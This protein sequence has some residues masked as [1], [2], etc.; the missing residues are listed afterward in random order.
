MVGRGQVSRTTTKTTNAVKRRRRIIMATE[1]TKH[2]SVKTITTY[3]YITEDGRVFKNETDAAKWG[4]II[5]VLKKI[6]MFYSNR[7]LIIHNADWNDVHSVILEN[8][9][10]VMALRTLHNAEYTYGI[11]HPGHW[12]WDHFDDCFYCLEDRIEEYTA[13]IKDMDDKANAASEV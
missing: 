11:D 6:K 4:A 7:E 9:D 5:H 2:Y 1:N 10:Q 12:V 13:R 8:D 3:E